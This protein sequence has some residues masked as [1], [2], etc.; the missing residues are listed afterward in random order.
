MSIFVDKNRK[1]LNFMVKLNRLSLVSD[2]LFYANN[3]RFIILQFGQ[4]RRIFLR[5]CRV[6]S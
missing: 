1:C 4:E 6:F 2:S 3:E 5:Q